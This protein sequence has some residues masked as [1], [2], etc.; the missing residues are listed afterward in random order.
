MNPEQSVFQTI[1]KYFYHILSTARTKQS[2]KTL[3]A[4]EL[5]QDKTDRIMSLFQVLN[6]PREKAYI[7][8]QNLK[9]LLTPN[10][11]Y[12]DLLKLPYAVTLPLYP[13]V[14]FVGVKPDTPKVIASNTY[15]IVLDL[16]LKERLKSKKAAAEL[17][18]ASGTAQTLADLP[19][20]K[21]VMF[22]EGD[23]LRQDQLALQLIGLMDQVL[24]KANLNMN[25]TTYRVLA[26]S[27]SQ[28]MVEFV[29]NSYPISKVIANFGSIQAFFRNHHPFPHKLTSTD[30]KKQSTDF[31]KGVGS[32]EVELINEAKQDDIDPFVL[33][34]FIRS[35]AGDRK[36]VV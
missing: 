10:G 18:H 27:T 36:S 3:L 21:R 19:L 5:Q 22:K 30:V 8:E 25:L 15:P 17:S 2:S 26:T 12:Q 28:G 11:T 6:K 9:Q 13:K 7:R 16:I 20:L 33:S 4:L 24:K 14:K 29:N 23:D 1:R 34:R 35:C 32:M 31:D